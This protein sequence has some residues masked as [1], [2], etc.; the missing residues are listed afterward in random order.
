MVVPLAK[1][2]NDSSTVPPIERLRM[3]FVSQRNVLTNTMS[4]IE[5]PC[6][7]KIPQ[8]AKHEPTTGS[9]PVAALVNAAPR[10]TEAAMANTASILRPSPR[11]G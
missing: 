8:V 4:R 1:A 6:M 5:I 3:L 9:Q 2:M 7:V 10:P 11:A